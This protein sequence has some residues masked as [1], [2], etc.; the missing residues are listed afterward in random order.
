MLVSPSPRR[1]RCG[2]PTWAFPRPAALPGPSL[3]R[4]PYLGPPLDTSVAAALPG[5]SLDP[6]VNPPRHSLSFLPF[7]FFFTDSEEG[8]LASV[9]RG[10]GGSIFHPISYHIRRDNIR[11][12][13]GHHRDIVGTS[14]GHRCDII[15]TSSGHHRD[16]IRTSSGHHRDTIETSSGRHRDIIKTSSGHH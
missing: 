2:C 3:D 15:R 13:S 14:S 12:S 1:L 9:G 10:A 16:I 6:P 5:P 4:L 7:F 8:D 11:T